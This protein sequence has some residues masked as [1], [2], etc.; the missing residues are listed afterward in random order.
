MPDLRDSLMQLGGAE[1]VRD[2]D[3]LNWPRLLLGAV[4]APL[5]ALSIALSTNILLA[6]QHLWIAWRLFPE[7]Q[8]YVWLSAAT[9]ALLYL[10]LISRWR[11][12]VSFLEC[13]LVGAVGPFLIAEAYFAAYYVLNMGDLLTLSLLFPGI[14]QFSI[15]NSWA[16]AGLILGAALMPAGVLSGWVFWRLAIAPA[17]MRQ[18]GDAP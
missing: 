3:M 14:F 15:L 2:W 9:I 10:G 5:P 11:R 1:H 4:L 6:S 13:L 8:I 7:P 17:P 18:H 12:Q 16:V